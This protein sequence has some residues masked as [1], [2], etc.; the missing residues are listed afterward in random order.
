MTEETSIQA[1]IEKALVGKFIRVG[2]RRNSWRRITSVDLN[3]ASY[4]GAYG[5][6]IFRE[7]A[8]PWDAGF[9]IPFEISE[10]AVQKA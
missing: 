7:G 2:G 8:K 6:T 10:N 4:E 1:I 5:Y 3:Y 9:G